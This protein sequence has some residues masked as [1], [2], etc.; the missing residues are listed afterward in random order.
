MKWVLSWNGNSEVILRLFGREG[1][2]ALLEINKLKS[3][4]FGDLGG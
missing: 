4:N 3:G 2:D 1:N